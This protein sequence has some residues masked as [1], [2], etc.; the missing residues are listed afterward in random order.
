M[1]SSERWVFDASGQS[2][3]ISQAR[4]GAE[5]ET[6]RVV[7]ARRSEDGKGATIVLDGQGSENGKAVI[8]RKILTRQGD[9]LRLTKMTR[10][11]GEPFLMRQSYELRR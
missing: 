8:A 1:R 3:T 5:P 10:V 11:A 4:A 2:L 6:W 9:R 7:E